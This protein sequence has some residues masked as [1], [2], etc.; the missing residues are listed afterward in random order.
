LDAR[1]ASLLLDA[2]PALAGGVVSTAAATLRLALVAA[3][4]EERRLA[5]EEPLLEGAND[6]AAVQEV[7]VALRL[8]LRLWASPS[9]LELCFGTEWAAARF[10]A[11]AT[12]EELFPARPFTPLLPRMTS[13]CSDDSSDAMSIEESDHSFS[14][15]LLGFVVTAEVRSRAAA[16]MAIGDFRTGDGEAAP[17]D[18]DPP[19]PLY[20]CAELLGSFGPRFNGLLG[21][22]LAFA[23]AEAGADFWATL[24]ALDAAPVCLAMEGKYA[25]S[26]SL[27]GSDEDEKCMAF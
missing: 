6:R 5:A 2:L 17:D 14:D 16:A 1:P 4:Y 26:E 21:A 13:L 18:S 22:L 20:C 23:G 25:G 11:E 15:S 7:G 3:A 9:L 19:R 27:P 24:A 12:A 10:F 8:L